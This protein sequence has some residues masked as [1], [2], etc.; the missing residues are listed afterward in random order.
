MNLHEAS[1]RFHSDLA[2]SSLD[3]NLLKGH[4]FIEEIGEILVE[5][6]ELDDCTISP[7]QGR[8]L[9][10][11]GYYLNEQLRTLF[12]VVS[13][14]LDETDP[15]RA[16]VTN[17][18]IDKTFDKCI[19]FFFKSLKG[20]HERI[21]I[22]NEAHDLAKLI[23]ESKSEINDVKVILV[24]DGITRDRPAEYED[25]DG[26]T[27]T[28][29]IWDIERI[30]RFTEKHEK[31][32]IIVDFGEINGGAIPCLSFTDAAGKYT[33][34]VSYLTGHCLLNL[35][36]KWGTK[37]LEMNVRV[38]LSARGKVNK[39]IRNTILHEPNMF[40]AYNNG[41]T[42][43]ARKI[44]EVPLNNGII[45]IS[46]ATD[47]QIVNGGQTVA[48]LYHTSKKYK[49]DLSDISVQ[50]KLIVINDEREIGTL[51]PKISEYS[52]TQN[53]VSTADLN[54]NDPP[55]PELH[56]I[57]KRLRAPD[58][59]GGSRETY[60]FYEKSRGSYEETKNLEA[61]TPAQQKAFEAL[62]PKKQRFDKGLLGKAWNTYQKK[63]HIVCLGAQKNFADFNKWLREQDEDWNVFFKRT[64]A[65][66]KIWNDAEKIVSRQ[67]FEGYR[68]AIVAY[69]LAW[70]FEMTDSQI[71]LDKIWQEQKVDESIL[72]SI[73]SMCF[74]VNSHIR[75]TDKNITEWCKKEETWKLLKQKKYDLKLNHNKSHNAVRSDIEEHDFSLND[76]LKDIDFCK[77]KGPTRW[78]TLSKWLKK[79]N[80]LTPRA[81]N[82]CHN[83]G[84]VLKDNQVPSISL[85]KACRKIW[86]DSEIKGWSITEE[87]EI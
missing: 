61:K 74:V 16:K 36:S 26:F 87:K 58:P 34:Y 40:C 79:H 5:A 75:E 67:K 15:S 28:R 44:E 83:M 45:G 62:Y 70:L 29:I 56:E 81:R 76:D 46:N 11:D 4:R 72:D 50:M 59:T 32:S 51:V 22:S 8:G 18:E 60:W 66:V 10:V 25:I 41:I 3:L 63:P 47:F 53:K 43:F 19:K 24:T 52:N 17:S 39:G 64:V 69:T 7:Y 82:Q 12:L 30:L 27:I 2:S 9:K 37:L 73:E 84:K 49:A 78:I 48:S 6:G 23:H 86:E 13:H 35:Y 33:T 65:L 21:E 1:E 85:A 38:F 68:H 31:E 55:H 20:L 14:W 77:L 42:V 71:D 57:S 80:L 54:A